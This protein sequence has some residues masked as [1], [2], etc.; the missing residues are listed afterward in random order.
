M[1]I[2]SDSV[3]IFDPNDS[4]II[5]RINEATLELQ[6]QKGHFSNKR[7]ALL[8][9][10]GTYENI[11]V[12]VGYY[13]TASGLGKNVSDTVFTGAKGVYTPAAD[14]NKAGSLDTFW[15]E[16]S[17]LKTG[18]KSMLYAVSQAA[19]L[20]RV[21]VTNDLLLHDEGQW[22]SGQFMANVKVNNATNLGSQQQFSFRNC[23]FNKKPQN[24]V[25]NYVYVGCDN[26]SDVISR[27]SSSDTAVNVVEN[28]PII[29]EKPFITIDED[30][31]FYLQI[32]RIIENSKGVDH[33]CDNCDEISFDDVYVAKSEIDTSES[34]QVQLDLCKNIVFSPGIYNLDNSLIVRYNKQVLL[35]LGLATLVAPL[36]GDPCILVK[37]DLL[38]VRICGFMLEASNITTYNFSC[39]L[40]WGEKT[41]TDLSEIKKE[42]VSG[43]IY[44]VYC[45]VGGASIDRNVSVETM[46]IINSNNVIG[47]GLWLWVCDHALLEE[48]EEARPKEKYH[49][50][51]MGECQCDHALVVNG[52]NVIMYG[53]ASEHSYNDLVV[54]NGEC[55][56]VYFY[57]CELPYPIDET[58]ED[59][60]GYRVNEEV[61][62]H[63]VVGAG[64][65][66]FMR[67]YDVKVKTAFV[68]PETAIFVNPFTF[69][70]NGKGGIK[71]VLNGKGD[72]VSLTSERKIAYL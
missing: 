37:D 43:F 36:N 61:K 45:R 63:L 20:R 29:A 24:Y 8:F 5:E 14:K 41:N 31:K 44:D 23:S 19:P 13:M 26:P 3:L 28:T 42:N 60:V 55:G 1:S 15:R 40:K 6:S 25:W 7:I 56:K 18:S 49:L 27:T 4:D 50:T 48:G 2:F 54:W 21:E 46:I 58:Y 68:A 72:E 51:V 47:D 39:L 33:T 67:D 71:S 22:A 9:K 69:F 52:N 30:D 62:D 38:D 65:Y 12:L 11:D 32:P 64:I 66:S 17:N 70:L 59:I 10:P 53:L 57:Q 35:G 34:I 16:I